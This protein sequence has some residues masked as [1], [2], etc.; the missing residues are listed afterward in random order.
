M[1]INRVIDSVSGDAGF[2]TTTNNQFHLRTNGSRRITISSAGLV[3]IG[4]TSPA[5]QLDIVGSTALTNSI[6]Q[7]LDGTVVYQQWFDGTQ[8]T[9][10]TFSNHPLTF[11]SNN[12]S[13]Q[14]SI[15]TNGNVLVTNTLSATTLSAA[16][17][18]GTLSTAAQPNITS[19]G[20]LC[21]LSVSES[22]SGTLSTAAQ[23]NITSVGNLTSLTTTFFLNNTTS[24]VNYQTWSN[25]LGTPV[26]SALQTSNVAPKF[27]TNCGRDFRLMTNSVT[28]IGDVNSTGV[29]RIS[30]T[31][32]STAITGITPG[33]VSASKAVIAGSNKVIAGM[34][35]IGNTNSTANNWLNNSPASSYGLVVSSSANTDT[36]QLGSCIAFQNDSSLSLKCTWGTITLKKIANQYTMALC[37]RNGTACDKAIEITYDKALIVNGAAATT[38]LSVHGS[39]A[40]VDGSFRRVISARSDNVDPIVFDIQCHSG[41]GLTTT[42]AVAIGTLTNND[43]RFM[44][45]DSSKMTL[46]ASNGYLGIGT[47]S[48]SAPLSVSGTA[49]NTFNVGGA[50]RNYGLYNYVEELKAALHASFPEQTKGLSI[51]SILRM[52]RFELKLSR[53]VR[54]LEAQPMKV[55]CY[56]VIL[57]CFYKHPEQLL[58]IEQQRTVDLVV[59]DTRGLAV[60]RRVSILAACDVRGFVSWET[61]RGTFI[62]QSFHRGFVAR[63]VPYLNPW[64]LPRSIVIMDNALIHMYTELED[65][66]HSCG[67]ILLFLEHLHPL[68]LKVSVSLFSEGLTC[69]L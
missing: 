66:V 45:N 63:I 21:S 48:P 12:G 53:K 17:L 54:A 9:L 60:A 62:R 39:S 8:C 59:D 11:A 42:T 40:F 55:Q 3:G 38:Q 67:A 32:I 19:I 41:S 6:Y 14:M 44:V 34:E 57:A 68:T 35:K 61:T 7:I 33:V 50:L 46:A 15:L 25:S 47:T 20:T 26:T 52:L 5:K 4:T 36:T 69:D 37:T 2:G 30:G 29:Y 24:L 31:D 10:Q 49:S 22:I 56:L 43:L 27:G 16:T 64:P 51:S 1:S 65:A 23:T 13:P 28:A 18:S 58:F